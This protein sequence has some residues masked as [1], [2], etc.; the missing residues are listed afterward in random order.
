MAAVLIIL[1]QGMH[2][3]NSDLSIQQSSLDALGTSSC[4]FHANVSRLVDVIIDCV[5]GALLAFV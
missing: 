4:D 3:W 2:F 5:P 1:A